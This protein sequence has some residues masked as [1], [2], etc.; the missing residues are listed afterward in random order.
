MS[1]KATL[2][3]FGG[4]GEDPSPEDAVKINLSKWFK[5]HGADVYWEKRPSYGYQVFRTDGGADH[6]DLLADGQ[7]QTFA[8]EVKR[9]TD[10]A[11][12]HDGIAQ[13]KRYWSD[14]TIGSKN[15]RLP[16]GNVDIDAFIL[17]TKHAP[18]G[19]LFYRH[20]TRDTVRDMHVDERFEDEWIDPPIHF[21]PDWEFTNTETATRILWRF[22]K[23]GLTD[24]QRNEIDAGVGTLLSD[25]LDGAQPNQLM[26]EDTDPFDHSSMPAPKALYRTFGE[27]SGIATH[28]WRWIK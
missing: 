15:Y 25:R 13:T 17:A 16:D 4:G 21:L 22:C 27:S 28:N 5:N 14:Y 8:V 1:E 23:M 2:T 20:G 10:G 9:G 19:R 24:Q 3:D 11:G 18:D 26:P 7:A 12:I 6:P